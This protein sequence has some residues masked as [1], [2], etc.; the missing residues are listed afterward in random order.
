MMISNQT[1]K[2]LDNEQVK[3]KLVENASVNPF[4]LLMNFKITFRTWLKHAKH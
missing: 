3:K 2:K 4:L 1:I